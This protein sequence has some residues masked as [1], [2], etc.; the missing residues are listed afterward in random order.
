MTQA[1]SRIQRC[2]AAIALVAA[3]GCGDAKPMNIVLISL[4]TTR[5]DHL[6]VYGYEKQ[7]SPNLDRFAERA[8]VY[9]RAYSTSSWTLPTH[10]SIFT[11]LLPMQHGAQSD[12][13]SENRSL[14]YGV[15]PLAE[16]FSTLGELLR[17][18]G[19]RT[20]AVVGGPALRREFGIAQ[21]FDVYDDDLTSPRDRLLGKRAD[22]VS[23]A[24]IRLVEGFGSEPYFLFVNFFDPHAPYDPPAP[25]DHGLLDPD[26]K[27]HKV[28]LIGRLTAGDVSEPV[29]RYPA[30]QREWIAGMLDA[31]DAEI[32]YMDV[33]LGHLLDAIAASPRGSETLI[34]I[35]SDHGESFGEHFYLSHGAH[36][37]EDNVRVPL[38]LR[39]PGASDGVRV[40]AQ[41]Q[42]HQLF[43]TLLAAA[44]VDVP[45]GVDARG[46]E[47]TG[48]DV[49]LEVRRSDLNVKFFGDFFDRDQM[50]IQS[51]PYKLVLRTTG[52]RELFDLANDPAEL[53]DLSTLEPERVAELVA[54]LRSEAAS[55]PPMYEE[56]DR[57]E[58]R[59][60][61]EEA[62]RALGYLD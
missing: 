31:Y 9:E 20:G 17:D 22:Q 35:T 36:L 29:D 59:P 19:Y 30:D 23:Q 34:A 51:W 55:H 52:E 57:P 12:P 21:G 38:L 49:L 45:A 41:V 8:T 28:R 24:A 27:E 50:A 40:A 25:Y 15:R 4:D 7:T 1:I 10:A 13:S 48:G 42:N 33:H 46:L 43:P 61:T 37:Y 3:V 56:A 11:G 16:S 5:A 18:A 26:D 62:L 54:K 39:Y 47:V 2:A 53:H 14:E 58:L 44:G 32:R 6:G 60:E